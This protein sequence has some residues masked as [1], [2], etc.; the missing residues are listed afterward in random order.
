MNGWKIIKENTVIRASVLVAVITLL[1]KLLGYIEKIIVAY[2]WGT[3]READVYTAVFSILIGIS[4]FVREWLEPGFLNMTL[5]QRSLTGEKGSWATFHSLFCF[6]GSVA[7]LLSAVCFGWP[8]QATKL[9]LSGFTG[10]KMEMASQ[11]FRIGSVGLFFLIIATVTHTYLSSYKYFTAQAFSEFCFKSIILLCIPMLHRHGVYAL[12]WGLVFG[13]IGKF[14]IQSFRLRKHFYFRN[15]KPDPQIVRSILAIS[16]PLLIGNL[17]SQIGNIV[18]N[19]FASYL[20]EGAVSG[21]NYAKKII[22]LPVILFPYT[23]SIVIFPFFSELAIEKNQVRL[24][25]LLNISLKYI[26][27][28]FVPLTILIAFFSPEITR[29]FFERGAF[30]TS[31]TNLTSGAL[32]TY[33]WGMAA[34]ALEA[35]LVIFLF[36]QGRIKLPVVLGIATVILDI[37]LTWLL[38]DQCGFQAIAGAQVISKWVKVMM[39]FFFTRS[40]FWQNI[41]PRRIVRFLIALLFFSLPLLLFKI[42]GFLHAGGFLVLGGKLLLVAVTAFGA[43]LLLLIH[44]KLISFEDARTS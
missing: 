9:F 5:R 15:L 14:A 6:V 13:A 38:I 3:N 23:L 39:L 37:L 19:T 20:D 16:L 2:Y 29:L 4:I 7:L 31:S 34:F 36:S 35:V 10:E 33:N 43:Y 42:L 21:L 40:G 30:D 22:D 11:F 27:L 18:D 41:Q 26:L 12:I 24:N 1:I 17:F 44:W 32:L 28:F 8:E 25:R